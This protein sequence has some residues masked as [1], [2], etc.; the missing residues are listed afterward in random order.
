MIFVCAGYE[1]LG[2]F[3]ENRTNRTIPT[4]LNN[5]R[6]GIDWKNLDKTVQKCAQLVK[7]SGK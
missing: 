6:E 2:C 4:R 7:K 5:L 1:P 3:L